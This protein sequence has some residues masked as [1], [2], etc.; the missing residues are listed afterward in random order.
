MT[1]DQRFDFLLKVTSVQ[2]AQLLG[3][4]KTSLIDPFVLDLQP[5]IVQLKISEKFSPSTWASFTGV[6]WCKGVRKALEHNICHLKNT[7]SSKNFF[8]TKLFC[9]FPLAYDKEGG[10]VRSLQCN[11]GSGGQT[12]GWGQSEGEGVDAALR[13]KLTL[14]WRQFF[15]S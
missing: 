11:R 9:F 6:R 10:G 13:K 7:P 12:Q 15:L 14:S 3:Q 4:H 2:G 5:V 8:Q 1:L